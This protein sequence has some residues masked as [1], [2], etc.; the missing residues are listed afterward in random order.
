MSN[1]QTI[2]DMKISY[3]SI[4]ANVFSTLCVMDSQQICN[5]I[6]NENPSLS[7]LINLTTSIPTSNIGA[8]MPYQAEVDGVVQSQLA[9]SAGN[10]LL[11]A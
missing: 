10:V 11:L 9:A 2:T 1:E 7:S 8:V 4:D 6:I 5:A 3:P